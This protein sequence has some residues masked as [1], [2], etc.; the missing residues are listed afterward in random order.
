MERQKSCNRDRDDRNRRG[1]K[2]I[3]IC[4]HK[5]EGVIPDWGITPRFGLEKAVAVAAAATEE[6]QQD[7]PQAAVIATVV[8]CQTDTVV[9]TAA[10]QQ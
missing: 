4:G 5:S 8:V 10:A 2:K 7:D 9:A 1:V 6:K 3:R